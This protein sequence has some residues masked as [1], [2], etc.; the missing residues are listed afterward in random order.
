MLQAFVVVSSFAVPFLSL[1]CSS[2]SRIE[3]LTT[4]MKDYGP[5]KSLS[6]KE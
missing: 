6:I 4:L 2:T 3:V 1:L 5:I